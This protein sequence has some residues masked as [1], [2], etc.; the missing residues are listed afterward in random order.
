MIDRGKSGRC[1]GA[2]TE[3]TR[4]KIIRN[5]LIEAAQSA[6]GPLVSD[7]LSTNGVRQDA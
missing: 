6:A 4:M 2:F 7:V 3:T 5:A 1:D